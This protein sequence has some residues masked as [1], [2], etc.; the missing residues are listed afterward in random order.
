MKPWRMILLIALALFS[1][2]RL[3]YT[4]S[5]LDEKKAKQQKG[6][7]FSAF[8]SAIEQDQLKIFMYP[9]DSKDSIEWKI[10]HRKIFNAE[11][12]S[13][14]RYYRDNYRTDEER[15]KVYLGILYVYKGMS[16]LY[17]DWFKYQRDNISLAAKQKEYK[18]KEAAFY[19]EIQSKKQELRMKG[20]ELIFLN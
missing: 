13:A 9:K 20:T 5:K 14:I 16:Y 6:M 19:R 11:L 10:T 2:I 3:A 4:C 17:S 1:V 12:D 8:R 18:M 7:E 15:F